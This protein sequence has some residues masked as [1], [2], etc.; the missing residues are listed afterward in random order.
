MD[1]PEGAPTVQ[2]KAVVRFASEPDNP[3]LIASQMAPLVDFEQIRVTEENDLEITLLVEADGAYE[4]ARCS[5][6]RVEAASA[7]TEFAA[8]ELLDVSVLC[9]YGGVD[10]EDGR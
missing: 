7:E 10:P 4:A 6:D 5:L 1:S 2:W 9:L 3:R 8:P